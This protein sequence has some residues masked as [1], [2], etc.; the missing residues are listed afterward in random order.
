MSVKIIFLQILF[1]SFLLSLFF[2]IFVEGGYLLFML[3]VGLLLGF[4]FGCGVADRES[5][6]FDPAMEGN[7][8]M[9]RL[10]E[11]EDKLKDIFKRRMDS[12]A[13]SVLGRSVAKEDIKL[14]LKSLEPDVLNVH[15]ENTWIA[16]KLLGAGAHAFKNTYESGKTIVVGKEFAERAMILGFL[17]YKTLYKVN[18][19]NP[20]DR[21]SKE[22]FQ[23][24]R[25]QT[26]GE[27]VCR[28]QDQN[29]VC[30]LLRQRV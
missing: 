13:W 11:K 29:E 15:D 22:I 24:A 10:P 2:S 21:P 27:G 18:G 23:R 7:A 14:Y 26:L 6:I 8:L 25:V 1:A 5:R 28:Q 19:R 9:D 17:P 30:L 4:A 12:I 20:K 3:S 16:V